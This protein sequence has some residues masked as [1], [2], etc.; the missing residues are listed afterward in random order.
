VLKSGAPKVTDF[1][2]ARAMAS[3]K[4]KT[5]SG[6]GHP[7]LYVPEQIMG[8]KVDGGRHLFPGRGAV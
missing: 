2:I 7:V 4:T 1:G 3:S 6:Q 8:K 5:G